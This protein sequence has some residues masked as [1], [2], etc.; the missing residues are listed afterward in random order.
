VEKVVGNH[1]TKVR[2]RQPIIITWSRM[3]HHE[4]RG[5][6]LQETPLEYLHLLKWWI[7]PEGK[8]LGGEMER[9][10]CFRRGKKWTGS[11]QN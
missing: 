7:S 6:S 4:V 3:N 5:S 2:R 10:G 8:T 11:Y 1:F 9:G